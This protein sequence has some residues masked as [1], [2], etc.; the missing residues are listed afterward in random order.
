M[1]TIPEKLDEL[2]NEAGGGHHPYIAPDESYIIFDYATSISGTGEEDLYIS[3]RDKNGEWSK[4]KNMGERINSI[5]RDKKAFVSFDGKYLFFMS[6]RINSEIPKRPL[7]L[8]ELKQLTS[9]HANGYQHL[10]WVSAKL[11]DGLRPKHLQE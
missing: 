11:I 3:F 6:N 10:Y 9:G 4:P 7:T 5:Y 8:K 1:Y 2:V